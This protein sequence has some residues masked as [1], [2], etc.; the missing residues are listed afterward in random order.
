MN[1]TESL[2]KKV[3]QGTFTTKKVKTLPD[4]ANASSLEAVPANLP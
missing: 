4:D 1:E 3:S 2:K